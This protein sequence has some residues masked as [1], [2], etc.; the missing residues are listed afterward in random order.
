MLKLAVVGKDVSQS[1]SPVIHKFIAERTGNGLLYD[2][3]SIPPEAFEAEIPQILKEYDGLNVTVPYK[4]RIVP[5]LKD[6]KGDA[7][8]CGAVNTVLCRGLS[9]YN[10]DGDGF[11]ASL[12]AE[13]INISGKSA[14]VLGAGG[15]GRIVAEKLSA[16]GAEV[17]V[18]DRHPEKSAAE[19]ARNPKIKP[20]ENLL[21]RPYFAVVNATGTGSGLT[22]GQ[23]PAGKELLNLCTVAIDLVYR[24]ARTEFLKT[25]R[26]CGKKAVNGLGML[27]FQAYSAQCV[28][29]GK[30]PSESEARRLFKEY[31]GRK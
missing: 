5:Y 7:G 21:N 15:A 31:G 30:E 19:A 29:F 12:E 23:S 17:S 20:L 28:F 11:M 24:P 3:I 16:C 6:L 27:F 26:E 13:N 4:I 2:K 18:Y 9:G 22:A 25:A 8:L 14:L 10:T 1:L